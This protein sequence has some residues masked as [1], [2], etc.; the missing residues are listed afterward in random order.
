MERESSDPKNSSTS[1]VDVEDEISVCTISNEIVAG[2]PLVMT[3]SKK[4]LL[5]NEVIPEH[6]YWKVPPQQLKEDTEFLEFLETV[7]IVRKKNSSTAKDLRNSH[8]SD[9]PLCLFIDDV[10][11]LNLKEKKNDIFVFNGKKFKQVMIYGH[12]I[13]GNIRYKSTFRTYQVDD[14][15]GSIKVLLPLNSKIDMGNTD[16]HFQCL[17]F[18]Q[19]YYFRNSTWNGKCNGRIGS[20]TEK[21]DRFRR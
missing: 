3:E 11:K 10:L 4:C 20:S 16:S 19:I 17:Q 1:I 12:V 5:E 18:N 14:G 21:G 6:P 13:P 9:K 2:A 7:S 8:V 15:T